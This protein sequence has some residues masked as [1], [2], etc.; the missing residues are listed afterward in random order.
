MQK[1]RMI[2]VKLKKALIN[3]YKNTCCICSVSGE[4]VPLELHMLNGFNSEGEVSEDDLILICPNCH[5]ALDRGFFKESEFVD[6][7][8]NIIAK[9]GKFKSV[10]RSV[11][12]G[13]TRRLEADIVTDNKPDSRF[14][15]TLIECKSYRSF[16]KNLASNAVNQ[17]KALGG[18][19]NDSE[20]VLAVSGRLTDKI[21]N[22]VESEGIKVW[23]LDY[24]IENYSK[25]IDDVGSP[26]MQM[27]IGS[28]GASVQ[29]SK[30]KL[31]IQ[32]L[33]SCNPGRKDC[34]IYQDLV[35]EIIEDVFCPP[36][37]K[38]LG[39]SS[40]HSKANRRDFIIPNYANDGFWAF[41]REKY[42]AD[43]IVV[44][45]K[46][47]TRKVKKADVLQVAN[48][49][50]PHG[51]GMFGLIFSRNGGDSAGC[52][53]TL[54]EQWMVHNKMIVILNDSDVENI[55]VSSTLGSATDVIGRKIEE[56]RLSM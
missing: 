17:L 3:K 7:L 31:L 2:P 11:I 45:A 51:A 29:L 32:K 20:L 8:T 27:L 12:L 10:K 35:G 24:L 25:E 16:S 36:L 46:N 18:A 48:Y 47:Y 39:E 53:Q 4:K 54:R 55:L 49:L 5:K 1:R 30:S 26:I 9:S 43:Y 38:P 28:V 52:E 50:K 40:D 34:Y 42:S 21:R 14:K 23:D 22:Q 41:L 19:L 56:F 33:K 15:H 13:D 44:D 37:Q 6:V